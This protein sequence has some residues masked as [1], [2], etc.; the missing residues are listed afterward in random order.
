MRTLV[1]ALFA[2]LLVAQLSI[3]HQVSIDEVPLEQA[4]K[5]LISSHNIKQVATDAQTQHYLKLFNEQVKL[6]NE[7]DKE[8]MA[9]QR[10]QDGEEESDS[11][12]STVQVELV[13]NLAQKGWTF[14]QDN[15]AVYEPQKFFGNA[16]P[17]GATAFDLEQWKEPVAATF[18][19]EWKTLFG[20]VSAGKLKYTLS[21]IPGGK[22]CDDKGNCGLYMDR[23]TIIPTEVFIQWGFRA[24]ASVSMSSITN[25][26]T[27]TNPIA[28]ATVDLTFTLSALNKDIINHSFYVRADGYWKQI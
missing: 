21:F 7:M 9:M 2:L 14:L 23:I 10:E 28:A 15:K 16:L 24:D 22:A 3:Q 13:L 26:G 18:L 4:T 19:V 20:S 17:Q 12:I 8:L 27:K 25:A 5:Y 1:I 11:M 6:E